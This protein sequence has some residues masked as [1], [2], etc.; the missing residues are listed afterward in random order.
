MSA[1]WAPVRL[2]RARICARRSGVAATWR[3]TLRPIILIGMPLVKTTCAASGSHQIL[4]SAAGVELP[5]VSEPPIRLICLTRVDS[6]E[7]RCSAV[8]MLVRGPIGTSD[9]SARAVRLGDDEVGR[10]LLRQRHGRRFEHRTVQPGLTVHLGRVANVA[11]QRTRHP[12]RDRDPGQLG[13]LDC[14]PGVA[15]RLLEGG[16]AKDG[17]DERADPGRERQG[18]WPSRRHGRGRSR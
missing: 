3:V 6:E 8:A 15:R 5:K 11:H 2:P 17:R 10:V 16:V 1:T 18:E 7:S 9:R 4:N 12:H 13:E 14:L